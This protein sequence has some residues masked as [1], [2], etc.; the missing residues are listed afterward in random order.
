MRQVIRNAGR[1][2]EQDD[3]VTLY[4]GAARDGSSMEV[5]V[6]DARDYP[7]LKVIV[8]ALAPATKNHLPP[9]KPRTRRRR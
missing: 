3:G 5:G 8:H 4:V 7:G 1:V 6:M 9:T 2:L